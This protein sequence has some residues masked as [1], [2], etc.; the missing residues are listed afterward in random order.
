MTHEIIACI[1]NDIL[2]VGLSRSQYVHV[3]EW[4]CYDVMHHNTLTHAHTGNETI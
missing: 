4:V 2:L 1:I 3:I